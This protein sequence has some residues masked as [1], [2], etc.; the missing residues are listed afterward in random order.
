[1]NTRVP[2]Q[3]TMP[4]KLWKFTLNRM[5]HASFSILL[6]CLF[7]MYEILRPIIHFSRFRRHQT[8]QCDDF[9]INES[10]LG[11][12]ILSDIWMNFK[13]ILCVFCSSVSKLNIHSKKIIY[14]YINIKVN[15]VCNNVS[16]K[17]LYSNMLKCIWLLII[18]NSVCYYLS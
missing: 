6:V 16:E 10:L 15:F 1:M 12:P 14:N 2:P 9:Y 18:S 4:V 17:V 5:Q 3:L 7:P 11:V 8:E 13:T